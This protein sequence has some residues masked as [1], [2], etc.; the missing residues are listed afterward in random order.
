MDGFVKG[1]AWVGTRTEHYEEMVALYRDTLRLSLDHE[2]G[3]STFISPGMSV[4][5]GST[6]SATTT[7]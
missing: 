2:E 3:G 6:R 4:S 1:L 5:T 7:V